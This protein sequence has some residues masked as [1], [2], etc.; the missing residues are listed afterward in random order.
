VF[1]S[2]IPITLTG[3]VWGFVRVKGFVV[4]VG[5]GIVPVPLL[6]HQGSAQQLRQ[7]ALEGARLDPSCDALRFPLGVAG[8]TLAEGSYCLQHLILLVR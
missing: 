3:V 8:T 7:C 6:A 4:L 2:A 5:C 1:F